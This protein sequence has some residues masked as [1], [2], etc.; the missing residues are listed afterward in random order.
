MKYCPDKWV[1]V[2]FETEGKTIQ[3]VLATWYGDY[4]SG[5]SW[6][7]S[8][9]ITEVIDND[10]QYIFINESGSEYDCPKELYGMNWY[11]ESI[12][13]SWRTEADETT[14]IKIV[15]NYKDEYEESYGINNEISESMDEDCYLKDTDLEKIEYWN[16]N[17]FIGL[18]EFV[19]T[20]WDSNYGSFTVSEGSYEVGK[21][22]TKKYRLTTG[23][24]S[25]NETILQAIQNND[26]FWLSCWESS[27]RGGLYVFEVLD[28]S[29]E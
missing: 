3:K 29:D 10:G 4:T 16:Y 23:G 26:L 9:G 2:E 21:L 12:Y 5:D 6:R 14:T 7:L 13:N 15:E 27:S 1:V 8:S 18:M 24:W 25:D 11:T 20:I 22:K 17:D 19:E 28:K